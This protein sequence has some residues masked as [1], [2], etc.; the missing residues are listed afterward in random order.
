MIIPTDWTHILEALVPLPI[1]F[2]EHFEELQDEQTATTMLQASY[3]EET[4]TKERKTNE[5]LCA[6]CG[7]NA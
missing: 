7:R 2:K 5:D 1:H 3:H 4:P 6:S